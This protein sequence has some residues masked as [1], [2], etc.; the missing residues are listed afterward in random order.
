MVAVVVQRQGSLRCSG[1]VAAYIGTEN[2][3]QR[4]RRKFRLRTSNSRGTT[5]QRGR[6]LMSHASITCPF[7]MAVFTSLVKAGQTKG[8]RR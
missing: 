6:A 3:V 5:R 4:V 7:R 2:K 8:I 1:E